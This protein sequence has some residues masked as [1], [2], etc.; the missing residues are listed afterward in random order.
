MSAARSLTTATTALSSPSR[1]AARLLRNGTGG[2]AARAT[3]TCSARNYSSI[4]TGFG[5]RQLQLQRN[6]G[7]VA[8]GLRAWKKN[9]TF[10]ENTL[11]GSSA[12]CFSAER[13]KENG[14]KQYGFEEITASLPTS[15]ST[16]TSTETSPSSTPPPHPSPILIDVREPAELSATGIIP[17]ALNIPIAS[18][19]D[20]LFLSPDEFLTRF[21][22]P[23]PGFE[24][25]P[26]S[27]SDAASET[28]A[29]SSVSETSAGKASSEGKEGGREEGKADLVFY[30][31]A[32]V[33]ARAMAELAVKA[34]Y[35]KGR[36][37]VY[38]GS[39]LDWEKR[40]GRVERWEG[41]D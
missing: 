30:C 32:G 24:D 38:E 14:F 10:V 9:N 21:G 35:D 6:G 13:G 23:K 18:H 34:G 26:A 25:S 12:R 11:Y 36:V 31:K 39:W 19:P 7:G 20:A 5:R 40:G 27:S 1:Y 29:S 16:S 41:E 17:T 4:T 28:S 22:F 33:R 2:A 37:G 15:T 3:T 8:T